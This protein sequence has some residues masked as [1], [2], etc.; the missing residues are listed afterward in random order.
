MSF[1][2]PCLSKLSSNNKISSSAQVFTPPVKAITYRPAIYLAYDSNIKETSDSFREAVKK[3]F[4]DEMNNRPDSQVSDVTVDFEMYHDQP[5]LSV[6]YTGT[7]NYPLILR[8]EWN[9]KLVEL[10]FKVRS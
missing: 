6:V 3:A 8:F 1:A 10:K 9:S 5:W 4:T 7:D 2:L